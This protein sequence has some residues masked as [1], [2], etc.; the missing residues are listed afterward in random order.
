MINCQ[1]CQIYKLLDLNKICNECQAKNNDKECPDCQGNNLAWLDYKMTCFD[2]G[3]I[4]PEYIYFD[5]PEMNYSTFTTT[6]ISNI[7]V[8]NWT[9]F[10]MSLS[11][12]ETKKIPSDVLNN[13]KTLLDEQQL[14][15]NKKTI[16]KILKDKKLYSFYNQAPVICRKLTGQ[17]QPEIP[18]PLQY[19]LI[20]DFRRITNHYP[21]IRPSHRKCLP[22]Y[23]FILR[24][25][26]FLKGYDD[27]A[28]EFTVSLYKT[29]KKIDEVEKIFLKL[30]DDLGLR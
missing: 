3:T 28:E 4:H 23:N 16:L 7:Q 1:D 5:E 17:V 21:R 10:L 9:K 24:K 14:E 11:G 29:P 30:K 22:N 8:W 2:C 15:Y 26:L 27:L 6:K 13:V 25:L 19:E 12:H 20:N 18:F